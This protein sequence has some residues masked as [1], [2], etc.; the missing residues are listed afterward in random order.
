MQLKRDAG[1][2]RI[3]VQRLERAIAIDPKPAVGKNS[4]QLRAAI[5]RID[6]IYDLRS[7]YIQPI[8]S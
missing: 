7:G 2:G 1:S 3:R 5:T 6:S 8:A 4:P